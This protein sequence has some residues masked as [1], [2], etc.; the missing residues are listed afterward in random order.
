MPSRPIVRPCTVEGHD[1]R[2][3]DVGG[4][5]VH[6]GAVCVIRPSTCAVD[7][8]RAPIVRRTDL[9]TGETAI[10]EAGSD[11]LHLHAPALDAAALT[12][13]IVNG[14]VEGFRA[15]RAEMNREQ[16]LSRKGRR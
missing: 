2:H 3:L 1:G 4:Q 15:N 8:C 11:L 6:P 9:H 16:E 10:L 5:C 13:G 7:G 14:I 12:A